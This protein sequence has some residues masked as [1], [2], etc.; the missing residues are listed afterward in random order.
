MSIDLLARSRAV[1]VTAS[2]AP[3]AT[4]PVGDSPT[5]VAIARLGSAGYVTNFGSGTVTVL[6]T[7]TRSPTAPSPWVPA[8]GESPSTR[9]ERRRMQATLFP[10]RSA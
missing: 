10:G 8:R 2:A 4:I 5:G 3:I 1:S 7:V 9:P 6:D